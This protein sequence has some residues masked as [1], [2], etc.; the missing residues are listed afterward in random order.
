MSAGKGDEE[1]GRIRE[2]V[3]RLGAGGK[4]LK[5]PR[6]GAL[7]RWVAAGILLLALAASALW[8]P[9]LMWMQT[10]FREGDLA[11]MLEDH[12][13]APDLFKSRDGAKRLTRCFRSKPGG[14]EHCFITLIDVRSNADL[15]R[16]PQTA[17]QDF[18][19]LFGQN[20]FYGVAVE[21][22]FEDAKS[23]GGKPAVKCS[24]SNKNSVEKMGFVK[25][26]WLA[27]AGALDILAAAVL[28]LRAFRYR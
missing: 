10:P 24:A 12:P 13:G 6:S 16:S 4:P 7:E 9:D 20:A 5:N 26:F 19:F 1:K 27:I 18:C 25:Y 2:K 3:A 23:A 15:L 11:V 14:A 22:S 28:L 17:A 8:K 21:W